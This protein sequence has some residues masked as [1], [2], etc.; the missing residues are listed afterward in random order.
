MLH[1]S[2]DQRKFVQ[3]LQNPLTPLNDRLNVKVCVSINCCA[4]AQAMM[5]NIC[6]QGRVGWGLI[7]FW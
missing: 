6:G 7:C 2:S 5:Q 1:I 4:P 3:G